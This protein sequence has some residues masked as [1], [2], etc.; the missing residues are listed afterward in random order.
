ME[1]KIDC[2]YILEI[3]DDIREEC[4]K[5]GRI[6][7]LQIPRPNQDFQVP[8]V[9]KVRYSE[10]CC[11]VYQ[12]NKDI[13]CFHS[14]YCIEKLASFEGFSFLLS[15]LFVKQLRMETV[16]FSDFNQLIN[17]WNHI[18]VSQLKVIVVMTAILMTSYLFFENH[19]FF[20][21]LHLIWNC[22]LT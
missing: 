10:E 5:Y 7:S 17:F 11:L 4:S 21:F 19:G 2:I 15:N 6:R 12:T 14:N 18:Q 8:S 20:R 9:G 1:K 16:L 13:R 22:P 3:F